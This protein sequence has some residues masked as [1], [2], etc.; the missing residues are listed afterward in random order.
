MRLGAA[1]DK[2]VEGETAVEI[3]PKAPEPA[4]QPVAALATC[5]DT[6]ARPL[7]QR[8]LIWKKRIKT[9]NGPQELIE[10]YDTATQ[11]CELTDWRAERA[12]LELLQRKVDSEGAVGVVLGRFASRPD[13]QKHLAK[14]I[15]RRAVDLRLVNAIERALFGSAVD[16]AKVD[17]ELSETDD[18]ATRIDKLRGYIA[19][20]PEDPNGGMRMVKL[21]AQAGRK[22]EALALGRRLRDQGLLTPQIARGLGDV[23]ARAGNADE[24]VRTYSEIVEFD[25]E[26]IDSRRLLGDIYLGHGW[27]EPAYRQYRTITELSQADPL[28]WLR[29]AAAAAGVGRIDE[30]L[31]L[32]RRVASAQG[33]PGPNDPRRWARLIS[34]ARLAR[35]IASPP[36]SGARP[37]SV[38]RELK[39]LGL[40]SGPGELVLLT[41]EDLGADVALTTRVE[42][43]DAPLGEATDAAKVGLSALLLTQSDVD[44]SSFVAR[45]RSVPV[46][47]GI[48]LVRH[49]VVWNGRDFQVRVV[50]KEL[51]ANATEVA[52]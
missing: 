51:A 14:L 8:V 20:A 37:E 29:L 19:K 40:F 42:K 12:F 38:K 52:L 21:L 27:Y 9:A 13:V 44:R 36:K 32:E 1:R 18:V 31:R 4:P 5:S 10:R 3:P 49:D 33:T 24:A 16:W 6:A 39:E 2:G 25:P 45:L 15:L 11:G 30:A 46:D 17:R 47:H 35:L 26:S 23:L 50:K 41:W 43:E 28:G 7:A 22:D 34:A 48:K